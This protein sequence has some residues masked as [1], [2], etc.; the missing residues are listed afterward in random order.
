VSPL[1]ALAAL[2]TERII[3]RLPFLIA[4]A[5]LAPNT[6]R[7]VSYVAVAQVLVVLLNFVTLSV[8]A[9]LLTTDE[10]GVIGIGLVFLNLLYTLQDFGIMTTIVQRDT[11]IEECISTGIGLRWI[12]STLLLAVI[13]ISAPLL[14]GFFEND[15]VPLVLAVLTANLFALIFA[16]SSQTLMLRNLRFQWL[17]IASIVQYV[18]L[19][20]ITIALAV[21]GFS[22]W[23]MIFG[24]V[25]GTVA[26]VLV[27]NWL[28]KGS[29]RPSLDV[30]LAADMMGFGKHLLV[31]ALMVFVIYNIDQIVIAR[32]LGVASLGVYFIAVRFG[33]TLGEQIAITLNRVFL[34][35]MSR[36]KN[37]IERL[38]ESYA[39][40]L[41]MISIAAVPV[42][43]GIAALSPLIV[44]VILGPEWEDAVV[45]LTILSFQ[46][47]MSAF[48]PPA[49]SLLTAVGRPKT[50]S[51]QS[52]VQ[53][54]VLVLAA[55][56][57][58]VAYGLAGVSALATGLSI[59]VF[60]YLLH[61]TCSAVDARPSAIL[62]GM[63]PSLA[64][65][66]VM[67]VVVYF[68][69]NTVPTELPYLVLLACVGAALYVVLLYAMSGG[70]D[71]R[72]ALTL[73]RSMISG[74]GA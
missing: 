18:V 53:A 43:V 39:R 4:V 8:L 48:I 24:S 6:A 66:T 71:L 56:P 49:S 19:A 45:P 28:Q 15:E 26:L 20:C 69:A 22:Y 70:R 21:V 7:N 5:D 73:A 12:S 13:L 61:V 2:A 30:R 47:L 55:Y 33:R 36:M 46:G 74:K 57:I 10:M 41:R 72:D 50:L 52:T 14:S 9:N 54:L 16:F 25:V 37:D 34:P 44:S 58:A 3:I 59:C 60:V 65:G 38:R 42:S 40:S 32:A 11:R 64:S 29:Q 23:S 63:T 1:W 68:A 62:R 51:V 27:S 17:S 67:F 35:T 31:N